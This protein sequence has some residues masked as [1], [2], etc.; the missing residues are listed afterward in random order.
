[1]LFRSVAE[2][3][4]FQERLGQRRARD[5]EEGPG[6]AMGRA[7]I[8]RNQRLAEAVYELRRAFEAVVRGMT[9]NAQMMDLGREERLRNANLPRG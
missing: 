6:R 9:P 4:R 1:M 8:A 3:L 2:H 5:V 7:R